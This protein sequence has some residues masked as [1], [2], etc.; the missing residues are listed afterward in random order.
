MEEPITKQEM[1]DILK[2]LA[3]PIDYDDL[4][5]KGVIEKSGAW[6]VVLKPNDLPHYAWRQA[7][8]MELNP[9]RCLKLKFKKSTKAAEALYK[10]ITGG[11]IPE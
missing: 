2:E 11:P 8:T 7:T 6:Y 3:T 4:I 10:K 9:H 5:A 1:L